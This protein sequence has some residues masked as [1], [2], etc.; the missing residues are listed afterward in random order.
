MFSLGVWF[1]TLNTYLRQDRMDYS[2]LQ[3]Q[4]LLLRTMSEDADVQYYD[5]ELPE[6]FVEVE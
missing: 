5:E 4:G 3:N 1:G 6:E 2:L